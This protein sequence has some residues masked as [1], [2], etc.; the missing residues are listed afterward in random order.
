MLKLP[1]IL[2]IGLLFLEISAGSL[3]ILASIR[4]EKAT[5]I[6]YLCDKRKCK[7][8]KLPCCHTS[9]IAHAKNFERRG[10]NLF[11]TTTEK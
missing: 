2:L 9:D 6:F 8:C 4:H 5:K 3:L 7:V 11:E 1:M 10:T